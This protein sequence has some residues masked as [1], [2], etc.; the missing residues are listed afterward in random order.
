MSEFSGAVGSIIRN[1]DD[2]VLMV[3]EGKDHI[4]GKW[5]LPGA[6]WEDRESIIECMKGEILEETGYEVDINGF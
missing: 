3:Q 4:H 1:E 6:G 5:D 2:E